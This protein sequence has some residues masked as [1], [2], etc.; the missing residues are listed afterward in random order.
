MKF[1]VLV[2]LMGAC[3]ASGQVAPEVNYDEAK[4]GSYLLPDPLR[5]SSGAAVGDAETWRRIRRP[6]ILRLYEKEVFG[7]TVAPRTKVLVEVLEAGMPALGAKAIRKQVRLWFAGKKEGPG[8]TMLVYLPAKSKGPA[9]VF[10]G[11]S[12]G[13][14]ATVHTDP[15]I[16]LGETWVRDP[17][18]RTKM[19]KQAVGEE[20]RGRGARQWQVEKIVERGFGLV[21]ACYLEI[22]PDFVGGIGHGVRALRQQAPAPDE[23][24]AL[25]AWAWGLSRMVD[26]LETDPGVD[27]K[28][29]AVIGHSRLGKAALWAGAQDERFALVISNNSGE[30]GA[31]LARRNYGETLQRITTVFPHWF[32]S[33]YTGYGADPGRLPVDAHM[34]LA[35]MAPRPVYVASAEE[36]RWA[37]PRGEFLAASA[38]GR[39]FELLG[40][41]GLGTDEMPG[42]H[43]PLMETVGYHVRAG[44]HDVTEYDW[45]QYLR[46]AEKHF[47]R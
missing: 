28:R 30:G 16:V 8:V 3:V 40:K 14:N 13:P 22:E 39:V 1:W 42:L 38:A 7:R 11:L 32:A 21:T 36:D 43:A 6:E 5:L 24:G 9:P 19:V 35:L 12:F 23:W 18:D 17:G 31:A 2:V 29:I 34:L 27:A 44:K 10:V 20:A 4:V 15:G 41:R 26:Y 47:G 45:E 33:N 25:G 46:F 37:D